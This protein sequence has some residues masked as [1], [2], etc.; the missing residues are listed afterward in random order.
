[1]GFKKGYLRLSLCNCIAWVVDLIV[2]IAFIV[3]GCG[4]YVV[5]LREQ[6]DEVEEGGKE[7][8]TRAKGELVS[9]DSRASHANFF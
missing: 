8:G 2:N 6:R 9:F 3:Q 4:V 5:M 1:M 7:R